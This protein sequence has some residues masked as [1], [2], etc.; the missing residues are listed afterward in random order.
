MT[1]AHRIS[2]AGVCKLLLLWW[3]GACSA[4]AAGQAQQGAS[5]EVESCTYMS[6]GKL[7]RSEVCVGHHLV[8]LQLA[9]FFFFLAVHKRI[10][11]AGI[12]FSPVAWDYSIILEC[13]IQIDDRVPW[14]LWCESLV[15]ADFC[16]H[17]RT[18]T[19]TY[20]E[21]FIWNPQSLALLL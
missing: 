9:F 18:C 20:F 8:T 13:L 6:V 5:K 17:Q 2:V 3:D 15:A 1:W 16:R 19:V 4:E 10:L 7:L 21:G 14:N 11:S 12:F